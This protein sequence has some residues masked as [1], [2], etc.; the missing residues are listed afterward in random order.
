MSRGANA[1]LPL[2]SNFSFAKFTQLRLESENVPS[3]T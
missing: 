2:A 1:G 3:M